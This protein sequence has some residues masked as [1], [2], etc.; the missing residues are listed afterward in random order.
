LSN[1]ETDSDSRSENE[2][3]DDQVLPWSSVEQM[4]TKYKK[5]VEPTSSLIDTLGDEISRVRFVESIKVLEGVVRLGIRHTARF[6]PTVEDF[7]DPLQIALALL[8]RDGD[9]V[10]AFSVEI[11]DIVSTG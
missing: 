6:E 1:S 3:S 10:D 8:R 4:C 7:L 11:G 5:G 9:T 2:T